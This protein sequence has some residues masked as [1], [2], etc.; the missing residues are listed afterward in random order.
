MISHEVHLAIFSL[1]FTSD[2][3]CFSGY[4]AKSQKPR[5]EKGKLSHNLSLPQRENLELEAALITSSPTEAWYFTSC[6]RVH[7]FVEVTW[8]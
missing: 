3:N 8:S 6:K 7:S 5:R 1:L 2:V 4:C